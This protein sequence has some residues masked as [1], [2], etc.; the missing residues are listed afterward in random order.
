MPGFDG[1]GP[2]GRG[3]MTGGGRGFCIVSLPR[4]ETESQDST[5]EAP[6]Q[7]VPTV[8]RFARRRSFMGRG[9]GSRRGR[10]L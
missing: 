8:G 2:S 7:E 1:S 3:S 5:V 10:M 4:T 9:Y 6:T